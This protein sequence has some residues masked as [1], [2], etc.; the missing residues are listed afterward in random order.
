MSQQKNSQKPQKS[1]RNNT[2]STNKL[3]TTRKRSYS[4]SSSS[5][6]SPSLSTV[7]KNPQQIFS[8]SSSAAS[9]SDSSYSILSNDVKKKRVLSIPSAT[10]ATKRPTVNKSGSNTDSSSESNTSPFQLSALSSSSSS[11]GSFLTTPKNNN[12]VS[13]PT[14]L[15]AQ[16]SVPAFLN[17]LYNMVDDITTNDLI[18][19]SE[20]DNSFIVEKHEEFAK[21]VLPR[22]YKHNTFASFVRQLNMYDFHKVPHLQQGVLIAES[23]HEIWEFSNPNF[24]RGRPDLLIFATRKRN[25]DRDIVNDIAN[26]SVN[27]MHFVQD[28]ATLKQ[29]QTNLGNELKDLHR[30]NEI[31][32]QETLNAREKYQR[33]Q[34]TIEK[35]LQFLTSI[36][37]NNNLAISMNN[38]ELL[39]KGLIEEAA[40]LAGTSTSKLMNSNGADA[41]NSP[42]IPTSTLTD[43]LSSVLQLH[44][45]NNTHNMR[46][47]NFSNKNSN[48]QQ[49]IGDDTT[50]SYNNFT[51]RQYPHSNSNITPSPPPESTPLSFYATDSSQQQTHDMH[52]NKTRPNLVDFSK[53]LNTATQS[54]QTIAQDIDMLQVNIESL[55]NNLSIDPSQFDDE[56]LEHYFPSQNDCHNYNMF[57]NTPFHSTIDKPVIATN[58]TVFNFATTYQQANSALPHPQSQRRQRRPLQ[59]QVRSTLVNPLSIATTATPI[60]TTTTTTSSSPPPP[61]SLQQPSEAS[62]FAIMQQDFTN[63]AIPLMKS[64]EMTHNEYKHHQPFM[65]TTIPSTSFI[66][67]TVGVEFVSMGANQRIPTRANILPDHYSTT[68]KESDMPEIVNSGMR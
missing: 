50:D 39:P 31:L 3:S 43:I 24:Q 23:E 9:S 33:H 13:S 65:T 11:T 53:T 52:T 19:W 48:F 55:A 51:Q 34:N 12:I 15:T 27:V 17:K 14:K 64:S 32:W 40:S 63:H 20:N 6:E 54:A 46:S 8:N 7:L 57:N 10:L 62:T 58:N 28:I 59:A 36:F 47:P 38:A 16:R 67:N 66:P 5:S 44:N 60:A 18:R 22:F 4:L 35:I 41:I 30:D 42:T 21:T 49:K 68:N 45:D 37:S 25:R 61:P 26:D 29:Q 56:N 2:N 1:M